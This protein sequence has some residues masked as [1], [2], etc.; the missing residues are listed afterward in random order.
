MNGKMKKIYGRKVYNTTINNSRL[1]FTSS[2]N[3]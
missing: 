3:K 1:L 2:D